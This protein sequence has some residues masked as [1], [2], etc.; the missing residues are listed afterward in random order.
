MG[1]E[2]PWDDL[3]AAKRTLRLGIERGHERY[4]GFSASFPE[5]FFDSPNARYYP[6]F[7]VTYGVPGLV[8][9]IRYVPEEHKD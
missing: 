7:E 9:R 3:M 8:Q 1:G 2:L 6:R 5:G 4:E